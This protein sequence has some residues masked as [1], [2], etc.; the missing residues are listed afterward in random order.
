MPPEP[1]EIRA[2][3][4][5]VKPFPLPEGAVETL[6]KG[7]QLR[8]GNL[9]TGPCKLSLYR[10]LKYAELVP[11]SHLSPSSPL[12]GV[13]RDDNHPTAIASLQRGERFAF[14]VSAPADLQSE[15]SDRGGAMAM[16]LGLLA[17]D[18]RG[19]SLFVTREDN[20]L[21]EEVMGFRKRRDAA[22]VI[23]NHRILSIHSRILTASGR[24]NSRQEQNPLVFE[25]EGTDMI[26]NRPLEQEFLF[27]VLL[28]ARADLG[29]SALAERAA[30]VRTESET[31]LTGRVTKSDVKLPPLRITETQP[32]AAFHIT[33]V[34]KPA[35]LIEE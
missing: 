7:M 24:P 34:E 1:S 29:G 30:D 11:I 20:D 31:L 14:A 4:P 12:G 16:R 21:M 10:N 18:G 25:A 5:A 32:I 33:L 3:M 17:R 19:Q 15:I 2:E 28:N 35:S 9:V 22:H 13:E 8:D 26:E 27:I 6:L 23:V